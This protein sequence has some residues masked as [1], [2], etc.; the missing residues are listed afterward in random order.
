MSDF[1]KVAK[2]SEI[3]SD[4][5]YLVLVDDLEIALYK[6]EG[7]VFAMHARCPHQGGPMHEGGLAGKMATC[8]WHGWEF[9]VTN[10]KCGFN[11]SIK[12]PTF[13]VKEDGEEIFIKV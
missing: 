10:G 4:T 7:K 1:I 11:P 3:P 9:D 2:K 13:E 8:P 5:G 12:L 6:V